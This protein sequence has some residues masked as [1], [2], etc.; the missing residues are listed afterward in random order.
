MDGLS[1]V[2]AR[3][4]GVKDQASLTHLIVS[5]PIHAVVEHSLAGGAGVQTTG[6]PGTESTLAS[7]ATP[8]SRCD[9]GS[10]GGAQGRGGHFAI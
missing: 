10:Q 4:A 3:A 2:T 8:R 9:D 6:F 1:P 7:T 5:V